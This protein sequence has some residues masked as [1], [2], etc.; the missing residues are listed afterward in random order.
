MVE[1]HTDFE[2]LQDIVNL[3]SGLYPISIINRFNLPHRLVR[4]LTLHWPCSEVTRLQKPIVKSSVDI[5]DFKIYGIGLP[6]YRHY[7]GHSPLFR[8]HKSPVMK[9][10]IHIVWSYNKF[11]K[12]LYLCQNKEGRLSEGRSDHWLSC[13]PWLWLERNL[14]ANLKLSAWGDWRV[15]RAQTNHL[16]LL[17]TH[18]QWT[19]LSWQSAGPLLHS[20]QAVISDIWYLAIQTAASPLSPGK[21]SLRYQ[22]VIFHL[23][24]FDII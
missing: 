4:I 9:G 11:L 23:H 12:C 13:F 19:V 22:S 2:Q 20:S 17:S 5:Y 6:L 24:W 15:D 21:Y 18:Q 10:C 14:I 3:Q 16:A 7:R 1:D 8:M